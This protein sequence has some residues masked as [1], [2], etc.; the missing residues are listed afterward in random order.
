MITQF[1]R[2]LAITAVIAVI[3]AAVFALAPTSTASGGP[4]QRGGAP[5]QP[6]PEG[7][8]EGRGGQQTLLSNLLISSGQVLVQFAITSVVI[9]L[10]VVGERAISARK[11][12]TAKNALDTEFAQLT[13]T[14]DL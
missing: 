7:R 14:A 6:R 11:R 1:L 3:V 12:N 8:P 13:G 4:P 9:A 2:T 10:V 5:G